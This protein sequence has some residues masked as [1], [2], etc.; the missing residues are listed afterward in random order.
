[1]LK[2]SANRYYNNKIREYFNWLVL[3]AYVIFFLCVILNILAYRGLD[4]K[5]GPVYASASYFL[6]LIMGGVFLK[7]KITLKRI[8]GNILIILGII[9]FNLW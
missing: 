3:V 5:A 2:T 6:V 9:I 7:E 4:L 1:M 8:L